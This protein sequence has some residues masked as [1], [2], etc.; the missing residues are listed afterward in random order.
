MGPADDPIVLLPGRIATTSSGD[1]IWWL[2]FLSFT[3]FVLGTRLGAP[4]MAVCIGA[5]G[6]YIMAWPGRCWQWME[7]YR[8]PWLLPLF[9]ISSALWS[10][11]PGISFKLGVEFLLFTAVSV[12]A[13]R[14]QSLRSLISSFM[15]ALLVGILLSAVF[16]TTAAIGT[17]GE[18]ALIGMFGSKNNLASFVCL[19]MISSVSVLL[20]GEQPH[21]LRALALLGL[22]LDPIMLVEA[23]SL[24]ALLA[25]GGAIAATMAFIVLSRMSPTQRNLVLP[26]VAILAVA[27]GGFLWLA[28]QQGFD[29]STVLAAAGKDASLTGRTFL[30][31]RARDYISVRPLL[32]VGYQSFWVQGHVEAE[33]LW[34]F[35]QIENR[36]GFHFHNLYYETAVELGQLGA[37]ILGL[38]MLAVAAAA[39]RLG[40]LRPACDVA[41]L[42]GLVVFYAIRVGVELDFL[43]P[44]S[45]GCFLLPATWIYSC[46]RTNRDRSIAAEPVH[47]AQGLAF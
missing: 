26:M 1:S 13:S 42:C 9:A 23:H 28:L 17:T 44:F 19:S 47:A 4:A 20:D 21:R 15:C 32:G 45:P 8:L 3:G 30:W 25:G 27:S 38:S 6:L 10:I 14:A 12:V 33:A 41:F 43:D 5:W 31:S 22:M 7:A 36:S 29:L 46:Q 16:R 39:L 37:A 11:E 35:A 40:L 18:I 34:R 24:G 2:S